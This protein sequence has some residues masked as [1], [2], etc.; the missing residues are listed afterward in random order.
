M[1]VNLRDNGVLDRRGLY[2]S[3]F[4]VSNLSLFAHLPTFIVP[5]GMSFG[6]AATGALFSVRFAAIF[7]QIAVVLLVSRLLARWRP[8]MAGSVME[9][10]V[11]RADAASSPVNPRSPGRFMSRVW[12]RSWKT[13][14]RLLVYL[15]PTFVITATLEQSNF[16]NWLAAQ[17]P[18]LFA[19]G[20]L[21]PESAAVIGAQ[22]VNLY[23]GAIM[24]ASFVDSGALDVRQAILILLTGTLVTAPV[25]TLKHSLAT[26]IAVLG[27]RAG[28]MMAVLTQVVRSMFLLVFIVL[29]AMVWK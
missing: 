4:V 15:A 19:A 8:L 14:R 26:Y 22:A 23:N 16:F 29:L 25:R 28:A 3:I 5:L 7:T 21:P 18:G 17:M 11:A 24:A 6:W 2:A 9:G 12:G 13:I 1:L 20:G 27:P 10:V